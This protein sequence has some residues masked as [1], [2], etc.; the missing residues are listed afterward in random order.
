MLS[1][2][3]EDAKAII[4]ECLDDYDQEETYSD[5]LIKEASNLVDDLD[6]LI[7][8]VRQWEQTITNS[9]YENLQD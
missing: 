6:S 7:L 1:D 2:V 3:L 5:S 8:E 4:L 9:K